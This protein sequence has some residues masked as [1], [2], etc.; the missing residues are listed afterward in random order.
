M[1]RIAAPLCLPLAALAA[2][3]WVEFRSGPFVVLSSAGERGG[4]EALAQLEQLHW[5]LAAVLSQQELKTRW[6]VRVVVRRG[7]DG[8]PV[9]PRLTR[10][11]YTGAVTARAPIPREWMRECARILIEPG[12]GRLPAEFESGL[13][14]FYSNFEVRGSTLI[15]G[16]PL[17][18]AARSLNWAR[19]H[20]LSTQP[21]YYGRLRVLLYNLG[22][23]AEPE[24]AYANALRITPAEIER[25]AAAHLAAGK[26]TT[27][28]LS[29]RPLNP[30]R[31]FTARV[32]SLA[33]E[34]VLADLTLDRAA[35]AAILQR[36]P[37]SVEALEGLGL[38]AL[39]EKRP[40]EARTRLEATC[41]AGSANAR[42]WLEYGRL[43]GDRKALEKAAQ[44]HPGWA[45]PHFLLAQRETDFKAKI[46]RLKKAAS[47]EPHN[48]AYQQALEGQRAALVEFEAAERRRAEEEK[49]REIE[50]LKAEAL[51]RIR[52]A[53]ARANRQDP[54]GISERKVEE[55]WEGPKP[56]GKVRGRL[57]Q[58]DCLGRV[59]R[60]V[61]DTDG[62]TTRLLIR[63][64][65]KVVVLGG[66]TLELACG[67]Q[68]APRLVV[69]EYFVKPDA[70]LAAAGEVA[71]IEYQ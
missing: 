45:E 15:A 32:P 50:A 52:A 54:P 65:K 64:P 16:Q 58:I 60:V 33:P 6:P 40:D 26:F 55:W 34:I 12:A 28:E 57:R 25:Q 51:A 1:R 69:I 8:S 61:I 59:L 9:S 67:A 17:P 5:G 19:I 46:E 27:V 56:E 37:E 4:R 3:R 48:A 18:E 22:Q 23:G 21:D 36:Q 30:Q 10:D 31:D 47:L 70:K 49:R 44:L 38:A 39:R 62:Q 43:A 63:D 42:V 66:G 11:A 13:A 35:Y 68:R 41:Q 20:L 71:T 29:G 24:P 14:D 2:Q 7:Q 53:E